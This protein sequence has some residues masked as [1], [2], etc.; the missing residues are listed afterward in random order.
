MYCT[1]EKMNGWNNYL[2]ISSLKC[3]NFIPASKVLSRC[4]ANKSKTKTSVILRVTN[5]VSPVWLAPTSHAVLVCVTLRPYAQLT[6]SHMV[7]AGPF[8]PL[9]DSGYSLFKKA[10]YGPKE[11]AMIISSMS[12]LQLHLLL[13]HNL[14]IPQVRLRHAQKRMLHSSRYTY[15]RARQ[16][17]YGHRDW[18]AHILMVEN[19]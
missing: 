12:A 14:L 1:N 6:W 17:H 8:V 16:W 13:I 10:S 9:M 15:A 3:P 11:Q 4:Y 5:G 7:L 19:T 18:W 2:N